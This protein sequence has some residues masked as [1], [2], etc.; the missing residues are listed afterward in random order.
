MQTAISRAA[1]GEVRLDG[2]RVSGYA[3]RFDIVSHDLGGFVERVDP[4]TFNKTVKEKDIWALFNHDAAMPLGHTGNDTLELRMDTTGLHYSYDTPKTAA[5]E[6]VRRAIGEGL[7]GGSSFAGRLIRDDWMERSDPPMHVVLE[8]AL[9]DVGPVTF[10]A[11]DGTEPALATLDPV[12]RSLAIER[13]LDLDAVLDAI[14][15]NS[16]G[17]ILAGEQTEP[18]VATPKGRHNLVHLL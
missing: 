11:Y 2:T 6:E 12:L 18:V 8:V 4:K 9:R 1:S 14:Q 17:A 5:G 13:S 3:A 7:L 15:T 16:L 10:Q